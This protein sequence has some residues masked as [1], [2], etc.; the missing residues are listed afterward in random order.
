MAAFSLYCKYKL[1]FCPRGLQRVINRLL[2]LLWARKQCCKPHA[3]LQNN[4]HQ[5]NSQKG[6]VVAHLQRAASVKL[7]AG[8]LLTAA[9]SL[10]CLAAKDWAPISS[11]LSAGGG[12]FVNIALVGTL[13]WTR[14]VRVSKAIAST[15]WTWLQQ[16]CSASLSAG[17]ATLN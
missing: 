9:V 6:E 1:H 2:L 15:Q 17:H 7:K 3:F 11:V 16:V 13:C 10:L 12:P 5:N 8:A 4:L 14:K